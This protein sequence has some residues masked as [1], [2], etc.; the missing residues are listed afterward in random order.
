[1]DG[2]PN[3]MGMVGDLQSMA[4]G[5]STICERLPAF[6][7]CDVRRCAGIVWGFPTQ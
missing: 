6:L 2:P 5:V 1:M 7:R 3:A 4:V